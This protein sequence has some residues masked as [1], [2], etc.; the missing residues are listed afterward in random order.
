MIHFWTPTR[1]ELVVIER[2]LKRYCIGVQEDVGNSDANMMSECMGISRC[3][4]R[5]QP[6]KALTRTS[7]A[8]TRLSIRKREVETAAFAQTEDPQECL[9]VCST[10]VAHE[11]LKRLYQGPLRHVGRPR[12]RFRLFTCMFACCDNRLHGMDRGSAT[13]S[14]WR[15][16]LFAACLRWLGGVK[17][18]WPRAIK[19]Q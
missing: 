16:R 1:R 15:K 5:G 2:I 10:G 3:W 7:S 19:R 4:D 9:S 17:R 11:K 18:A 13:K 14:L 8:L 12:M 6:E